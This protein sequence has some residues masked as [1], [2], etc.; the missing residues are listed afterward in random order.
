[1]IKN[2]AVLFIVFLSGCVSPWVI[3]ANKAQQ[4]FKQDSYECAKINPIDPLD[5]LVG[6]G[7]LYDQCMEAK[8][9]ERKGK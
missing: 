5:A 3:P 2:L 1:M 6:G 9:W 4:E 7:G 8:G